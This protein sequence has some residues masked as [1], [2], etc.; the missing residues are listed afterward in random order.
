[1]AGLLRSGRVE[2]YRDYLLE[3]KK[4]RP[5]TVNGRLSSLSVFARFLMEHSL[6]PFNPL[7]LVERIRENEL[8]AR[9]P[10]LYTQV[11]ALRREV[12]SDILNLRDRAVVE[13]LYTGLSVGELCS[14]FW[15][16]QTRTSQPLNITIKSQ[17]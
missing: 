2:E 4:L 5:S 16:G 11:Q 6:L 7:A 1:M 12:H 15:E 17:D 10:A 3:E 8:P 9:P 13:L 14:L